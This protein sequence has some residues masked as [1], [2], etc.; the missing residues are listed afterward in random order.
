MKITAS[1]IVVAFFTVLFTRLYQEPIFEEIYNCN[2]AGIFIIVLICL[3]GQI[4]WGYDRLVTNKAFYGMYNS[5]FQNSK[6]TLSFVKSYKMFVF[7]Y[8]Y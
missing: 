8:V 7:S 1:S 6:S 2:Q 5:F 3:Q 4:N